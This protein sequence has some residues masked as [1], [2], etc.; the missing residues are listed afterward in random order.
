MARWFAFPAGVAL[1]AAATLVPLAAWADA[2]TYECSGDVN[3]KF[4]F[5]PAGGTG[6]IFD[7]NRWVPLRDVEISSDTIIFTQDHSNDIK[8]EV[9]TG[10]SS[11]FRLDRA[12]KTITEETYDYI[13]HKVSD[14]TRSNGQCKIVP[15]PGQSS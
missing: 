2:V 4:T 13:D 1:I 7:E 15:N 10:Q 14:S 11:L 3:G 9:P 5:D 6:A 12:A 8:N